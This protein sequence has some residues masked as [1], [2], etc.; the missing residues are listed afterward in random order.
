MTGKAYIPP[1]Q[2]T[3]KIVRLVSEISEQVGIITAVK[4]E[5]MANPHLR[6]EN[7]IRTIHSSLAIENNT[8]SLEQEQVTDV[9][10]GKRI[11]GAPNEIKEVKN[12]FEA[13]NLLLSFDPYNINDLLKAIRF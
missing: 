7:Q 9:I 10:S 2:I 11:L 1:H 5:S 6:K 12:A 4:N 8:L 3:D 13:Y